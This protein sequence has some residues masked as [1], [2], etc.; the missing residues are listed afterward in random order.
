MTAIRAAPQH[1]RLV[2][3]V[4][5]YRDK[6]NIVFDSNNF[7]SPNIHA[8]Y[9]GRPTVMTAFISSSSGPYT[10][11]ARTCV[12]TRRIRQVHLGG[13]VPPLAA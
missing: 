11:S 7:R 4:V 12:V 10:R 8:R 3:L 6:R 13:R 1:A 5:T 9:D 2:I